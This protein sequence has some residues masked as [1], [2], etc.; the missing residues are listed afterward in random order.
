MLAVHE[1]F[2]TIQGEGYD[3]G[4][5]CTFIRL[6]GCNINCIY[7]DQP[8][9]KEDMKK[10]SVEQIIEEVEKLG[11]NN[12]CVTGGEPLAQKNCYLLIENL[13]RLGYNVSVETNGSIF[14]PYNSVR[15]YKYVMDVKL[16]SS[17]MDNH[18][19]LTNLTRLTSKDEVKFVIAD[20]EDYECM[21]QVLDVLPTKAKILLSPMFDPNQKQTIGK[22]L[23]KWML[24]DKLDA[25]ISVQM[26]KILGV[27]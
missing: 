16:P 3:T 19:I 11:I 9:N 15:D 12:I 18:N 20:R 5:P 26:H 17:K 25:R 4:I 6:F 8:Q 24:E 21:L 22:D 14:I 7:C 2:T 13:D 23:C 1:I 27:L 10:M